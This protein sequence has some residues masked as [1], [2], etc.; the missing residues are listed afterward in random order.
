MAWLAPARGNSM[1]P[2]GLAF[3]ADALLVADSGNARLQQFA[4]PGLEANRAIPDWSVP[5]SIAVDTKLRALVV[6][7]AQKRLRRLDSDGT[8]DAAFDATLAASG[9]VITPLCVSRRPR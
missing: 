3:T 5:V 8:P 4:L 1:Q 7:T 2:R 6:D 9:R